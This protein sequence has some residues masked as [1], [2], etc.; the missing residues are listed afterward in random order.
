MSG[1]H[2]ARICQVRLRDTQRPT[3][4]VTSHGVLTRLSV[5]LS[6]GYPYSLYRHQEVASTYSATRSSNSPLGIGGSS[7]EGVAEAS[8]IDPH[9]ADANSVSMIYR[10]EFSHIWK[11]PQA[12]YALL[13]V[14]RR[15]RLSV[16]RGLPPSLP[17][18]R[19]CLI[20]YF[21]R[22]ALLPIW[23]TSEAV[24]WECGNDNTNP[25]TLFE[26][27]KRS[28]PP[29]SKRRPPAHYCSVLDT[30]CL[31]DRGSRNSIGIT[32]RSHLVQSQSRRAA[33][34]R[35]RRVR[36]VLGDTNGNSDDDSD[37]ANDDASS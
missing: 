29:L 26:L 1:V 23:A 14:R 4:I 25:E 34:F 7:G 24:I 8:S 17:H 9:L 15:F 22:C 35:P 36:D 3:R 27:K 32:S 19:S 12:G 31:T 37:D 33:E 11:N 28:R 20:P 18:S 5:Y 16:K 30:M 21:L 10:N 13:V 2:G 6:E